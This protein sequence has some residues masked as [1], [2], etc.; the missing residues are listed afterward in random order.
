MNEKIL[1]TY[2]SRTGSTRGVAEAI[3]KTLAENGAQVEVLPVQEVKD[4]QAYR[5]LVIGSADPGQPVAAGGDAV[6]GA[7]PGCHQPD[8]MRHFHRLHDAGD[9]E[10]PV[11]A[12]RGG[13]AEAG[14]GAGAPGQRGD[15]RRRSW[16]SAR[17]PRWAP[18]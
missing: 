8:A 3:G 14:A 6:L 13:L 5:A 11:P 1:I 15:I 9:Q 7:A 4:L 2:A 16:I 12:G 18:G 10:R 17:C